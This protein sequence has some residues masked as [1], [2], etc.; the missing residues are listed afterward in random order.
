MNPSDHV[1][2]SVD[3]VNFGVFPQMNSGNVRTFFVFTDLPRLIE[4]RAGEMPLIPSGNIEL[5]IALKNP[6]FP[7]RTVR[8]KGMYKIVHQKLMYSTVRAGKM[9]LSQYLEL[10][11]L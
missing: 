4:Y 8:I 7:N 2:T 11:P 5:D 6:K 9:G 1:E 3:V 10:A